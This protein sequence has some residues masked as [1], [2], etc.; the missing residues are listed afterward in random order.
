MSTVRQHKYN[1]NN[2]NNNNNTPDKQPCC[3]PSLPHSCNP[4]L[5]PTAATHSCNPQLQPTAVTTQLFCWRKMAGF[6]YS[7][8]QMNGKD[9][10]N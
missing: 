3:D 6:F 4:Q 9:V 1:N 7:E 10:G 2:N 5:Q 8:C